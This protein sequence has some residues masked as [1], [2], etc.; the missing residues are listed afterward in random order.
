MNLPLFSKES[1]GLFVNLHY[2]NSHTAGE[3]GES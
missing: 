3:P 2:E 1:A